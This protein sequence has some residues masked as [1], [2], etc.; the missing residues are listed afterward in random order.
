M[1][2][3]TVLAS[4]ASTLSTVVNTVLTRVFCFGSHVRSKLYLTSAD[5]NGSPLC[6]LTP[7]RSLN[8][9]VVGLVSFQS[10]ASDG[11]SLPSG[12][13]AIRLSNRLKEIRMSLADVLK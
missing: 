9:H 8:V 11:W 13:R 5:E 12:W 2:N 4:G 7:W 10:V 1:V 6:H 3:T